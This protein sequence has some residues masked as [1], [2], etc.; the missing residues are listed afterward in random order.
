MRWSKLIALFTFVIVLA[1]CAQS[2]EELG[3]VQSEQ[4]EKSDIDSFDLALD[5]SPEASPDIVD[6]DFPIKVE[7]NGIE[8]TLEKKPER[9][10]A[11]SLDTA[12][13]VLELTDAS[14]V[15]AVADS[16]QNPHLAFQTN[17][18]SE[19]ANYLSFSASQDP[20]KV[21]AYDPDLILLTK[22]HEGEMDAEKILMQSGIPLVSFQ[23][24]NTVYSWDS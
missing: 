1:A 8:V 6:Q 22:Q 21:L 20:E 7:I 5:T 23:P 11:I 15:V 12:D 16:I 2:A 9:I 17:A 10:V 24:W 19:V 3:A 4:E 18:G 13:A 14:H